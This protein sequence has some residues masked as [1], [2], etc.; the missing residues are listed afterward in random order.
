MKSPLKIETSLRVS[1]EQEV[2]VPVSSS[3]LT[4]HIFIPPPVNA[5]A[6]GIPLKIA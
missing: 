1:R 6:W 2:E 3:P 5:S 4:A